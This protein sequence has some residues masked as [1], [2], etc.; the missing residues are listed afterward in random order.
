MNKHAQII[1]QVF[2][3]ILAGIVFVLILGYGYKAIMSFMERGE[4]VQLLDFRNQL[5]STFSIIK[6]DYGSVQRVDVRVPPKTEQVCF[7]NTPPELTGPQQQALETRYPLFASAWSTGSEN[8]FLIPRQPTPILVKD[9]QV[10]S[11]GYCCIAAVNGRVS[12][13]VEGTGNKALLAPWPPET[14]Q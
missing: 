10:M 11:A 4:Q 8:I 1:G 9:I 3:F 6:R 13:R 5:D 2:V 14:C 12:L 7:V